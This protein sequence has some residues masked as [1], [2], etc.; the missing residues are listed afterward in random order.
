MVKRL[1]V[2]KKVK[3]IVKRKKTPAPKPAKKLKK[4]LLKPIEMVAR[5][6]GIK[7]KFLE[8]HG[9]YMAKVSLDILR[10]KR[11]KKD[12]KYVLVTQITPTPFGEGKTVTAIGLSMALNRLKKKAVACISQPSTALF[13]GA[14]GPGTGYGFSQV[15]P[16]EDINMF[17]THDGS[18]VENAHNFCAAILDDSIFRGNSLDLDLSN[19]I[20]KRVLGVEDRTLRNVNIGLGGKSEGVA[21]KTGFEITAASELM[22][23]L[24][25]SE[26]LTDLK[27]RVGRVTVGF[28]KTGKPVTC[29]NL[30]IAGA[31]AAMMKN[32]MNPT[33]V[34]TQEGTPCFVHA[35]SFGN[36]SYGQ[37]SLVADRIGLKT[38]EYVIT[39][40]GASAELGAEKFFDLKCRASGLTADAIVLVCTVRGFKMHSGDYDISKTKKIPRDITRENVSSIERG[41]SNLE[42][43]VENLEVFG[44][45]IVLC[46]NRFPEDTEKEI[47]AI[48]RR[49]EGLNLRHVAVSEACSRGSEGAEA[50]AREVIAASKPKPKPR[51][52]Y[53]LD[54][55][56]KEKVKRIAKTL[57][58]AKE[59]A[60][61][62]EVNKKLLFYKKLK[63]DNLPV[64]MAKTGLSL[65]HSP[66]KKARP[67][68]FKLPITDVVPFTGAG[69][70]NVFC[71]D[72]TTMPS[73]PSVIRA[74]RIEV[75]E[76]G[77]IKGLKDARNHKNNTA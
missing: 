60:Y 61:S 54:L 41:L 73:L 77:K 18:A 19:I 74:T 50:L 49:A 15:L 9:P 62:D 55:P 75:D 24:E 37:T 25:I 72:I 22:A 42:K 14:K 63:L 56:I 6:I 33:I 68:G 36:I 70:I 26:D 76:E 27:N 38:C 21:R 28:T 57:Y 53:P 2:K 20:W 32:A 71:D 16:F 12:S 17:L 52:L 11:K 10:S 46:V 44:I 39:E 65:S 45:P 8:N 34:Q 29:E 23:L 31:I 7:K 58:G 69:F 64:C 3:K 43:Q 5:S 13:M 30:K 40:S 1:K 67:H 59:I 4:I 47:A 48:R 35:G 66:K 51:Y